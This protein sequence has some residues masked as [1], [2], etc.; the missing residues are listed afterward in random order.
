MK[1]LKLIVLNGT[2]HAEHLVDGKP[3]DEIVSL[4]GTHVIPTAFTSALSKAVVRT[5][6]HELNAGVQIL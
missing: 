2:W 4:F 3:C 6:L 5:R 1:T